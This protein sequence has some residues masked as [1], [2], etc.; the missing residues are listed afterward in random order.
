L[1]QAKDAILV[2]TTGQTIDQVVDEITKII[3]NSLNF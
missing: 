3:K 2:D 1:M